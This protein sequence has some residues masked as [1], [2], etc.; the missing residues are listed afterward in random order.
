M[1]APVHF[2]KLDQWGFIF[3]YRSWTLWLLSKATWTSFASQQLL[4]SVLSDN[5]DKLG[6]ANNVFCF[7]LNINYFALLYITLL[8]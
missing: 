8:L 6:N 5:G 2:I 4:E 3:I 7:S 1:L